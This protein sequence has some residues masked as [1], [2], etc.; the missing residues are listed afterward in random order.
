VTAL[1]VAPVLAD[2]WDMPSLWIAARLL[3]VL[4]VVAFGVSAT[5]GAWRGRHPV[6]T[7]VLWTCALWVFAPVW[8]VLYL[9]FRRTP[10]I[11]RDDPA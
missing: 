1:D 6:P 7:K 10:W 3:L 5:R 4:G 11:G 2:G 8:A 9:L